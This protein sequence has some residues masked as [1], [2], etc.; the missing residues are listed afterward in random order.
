[1]KDLLGS[2]EEVGGLERGAGAD[3]RLELVEQD[4]V[5]FAVLDIAGEVVDTMRR[6]RKKDKSAE[7]Y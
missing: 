4:S 3:I 6:N 7:G 5:V 2:L 1:M